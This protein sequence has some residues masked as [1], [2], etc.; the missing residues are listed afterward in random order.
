MTGPDGNQIERISQSWPA[1]WLERVNTCPACGGKERGVQHTGLKDNIFFCAP[2]KWDLYRCERCGTGYIDPRPTRE[3]IG[4]A[5]ETYYTHS[6]QGLLQQPIKGAGQLIRRSVSNGYV[7]RRYGSELDP[8]VKI[9]AWIAPLLPFF[10]RRLDFRHRFLPK[11]EPG[12]R[13]LDVGCGNGGFL[14]WAKEA[15]WE[16]YG[17]EPDPRAAE[18]ARGHGCHVWEKPVD[19]VSEYSHFFDAVTM[20]H[21]IEH[22][23]DPAETL[24][25]IKRSMKPGGHLFIETP[26]F[27][28][29]GHLR[30]GPHWRG[31]EP[32]R[33]LVIFNRPSLI[34]LL[35]RV[36]FTNVRSLKR[37]QAAINIH[38]KSKRL[39]DGANPYSDVKREIDVR[40]NVYAM[41]G[42]LNADRLEFVT[43]LARA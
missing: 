35:E 19:D 34:D 36:G 14:R 32:P 26:N 30:F 37:P 40:S 43:L 25:V 33:H 5:Y 27:D 8:A 21:V 38:A 24:C 11:P 20:S 41:L 29:F 16:P 2:G 42:W 15:G 17:I 4:R 3:T 13:L 31:L 23:H 1:D 12:M 7:N 6:D 28:S 18:I 39:M 22:L 10:K 9:G